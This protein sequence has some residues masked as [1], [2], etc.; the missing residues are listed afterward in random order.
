[1]DVG[2]AVLLFSP[3]PHF[4]MAWAPCQS[5]TSL[6]MPMVVAGSLHP[7]EPDLPAPETSVRS[8]SPSLTHTH[9]TYAHTLPSYTFLTHTFSLP[10]VLLATVLGSPGIFRFFLVAHS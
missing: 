3:A 6:G 1:M 8:N 7:E 5:H 10:A 2:V 4:K 9:T